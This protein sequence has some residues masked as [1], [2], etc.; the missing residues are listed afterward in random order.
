MPVSLLFVTSIIWRTAAFIDQFPPV[1][2]IPV[3]AAFAMQSPLSKERDPIKLSAAKN[4]KAENL[5]FIID[6][7]VRGDILSING[8]SKETTPYLKSI[9]EK[10]I[11]LGIASSAANCSQ[12]SNIILQSGVRLDQ[13]PDKD[14]LTLSYPSIFQYAKSAGYLTY[15]L[16][17]QYDPGIL[18]PRITSFDMKSIDEFFQVDKSDKDRSGF[19]TDFT[20]ANRIREIIKNGKSNFI[21]VNK[22][23]AHFQY[24][25]NYPTSEIHFTPT[26]AVDST[27][28]EMNEFEALSNVDRTRMVNSY[29]NALRWNVDKFFDELLKDI[30]FE[31]T[32]IVYTSD[33]GQNL[34]EGSNPVTHCSTKNPP[35]REANVPMLIFGEFAKNFFTDNLDLVKDK[36]SHFQI[37]PTLLTYM[38][39]DSAELEEV[40]G[41]P[42]WQRD[43]NQRK[44]LSGD[45]YG[46][47]SQSGL[48]KFY[49]EKTSLTVTKK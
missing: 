6:E 40:Y 17:G 38:G 9:R 46:R 5:I 18:P 15:W 44:F 34:K 20:L 39:Y 11:N 26:L 2:K 16:E 43:F 31:N 10:F 27:I 45:L 23:G 29:C 3:T 49:P 36:T 22:M 28:T 4:E 41:H 35:P 19:N 37:F 47:G 12:N 21:L 33:H 1:F 24:D 8:F 30:D 25:S 14:E 13:L 7:S 42:L 32:S 48:N